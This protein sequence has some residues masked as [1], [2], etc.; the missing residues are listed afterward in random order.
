MDKIHIKAVPCWSRYCQTIFKLT[1]SY[2][3]PIFKTL[4]V[5]GTPSAI[6]ASAN[7][8]LNKRNKKK[9]S[10]SVRVNIPAAF[11]RVPHQNDMLTIVHHVVVFGA[12]EN[13][14]IFVE[15]VNQWIFIGETIHHA[16][17]VVQ[18]VWHDLHIWIE[19]LFVS[20][21]SHYGITQ[22]CATN[23]RNA[24]PYL[25][26]A[27]QSDSTSQVL[28]AENT[29]TGTLVLWVSSRRSWV[30]SRSASPYSLAKSSK[31]FGSNGNPLLKWTQS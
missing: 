29:S 13:G 10:T 11:A 26:I 30:P 27:I 14:F 4:D 6:S 5:F 7:E 18:E 8:S 22:T 21:H 9:I 28:P 20:H 31:S 23:K 15:C 3:N 17:L 2:K 19:N 25:A 12:L 24:F 16:I 1:W